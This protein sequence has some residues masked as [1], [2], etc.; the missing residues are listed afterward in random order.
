MK[1][2]LLSLI[3]LYTGYSL[4][5]PNKFK[6]LNGLK[7]NKIRDES[8][9]KIPDNFLQKEAEIFKKIVKK[10]ENTQDLE[11]KNNK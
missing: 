2:Y 8:K 7:K 3:C 10:N 6:S 5:Q 9:K 4:V 11:D 1:F